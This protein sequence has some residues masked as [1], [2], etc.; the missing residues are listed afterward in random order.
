VQSTGSL[1][2]QCLYLH[3]SALCERALNSAFFLLKL[4]EL[5]LTNL[6]SLHILFHMYLLGRVPFRFIPRLAAENRGREGA[7][8]PHTHRLQRERL[9]SPHLYSGASLFLVD[10]TSCLSG[11]LLE[12]PRMRSFMGMKN[13]RATLCR[14]LPPSPAVSLSSLK[15]TQ[16]SVISLYSFSLVLFFLFLYLLYLSLQSFPT[17]R[18]LWRS[19]TL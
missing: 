11:G 2:S 3:L 7:V 12:A 13:P 8:P 15:R 6:V 4:Y 1:H 17:R 16:N 10:I 14:G 5:L 18:L 19:L 9:N